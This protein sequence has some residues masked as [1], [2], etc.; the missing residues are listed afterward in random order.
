MLSQTCRY[1][2]VLA[3]DYPVRLLCVLM[4]TLEGRDLKAHG[5]FVLIK[6]RATPR[7]WFCD[8]QEEG[9][10]LCLLSKTTI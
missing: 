4:T 8:L 6:F 3:C 9:L 10:P 5:E 1:K 7:L 2:A